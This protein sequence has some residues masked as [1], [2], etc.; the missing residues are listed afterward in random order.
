MEHE[1]RYLGSSTGQSPVLNLSKSNC[2]ASGSEGGGTGPEDEDEEDEGGES[3]Q[4]DVS[5]KEQDSDVAELSD[6]GE[7]APSPAT[8]SPHALNYS[9]ALTSGGPTQ[10]TSDPTISST[11][12]LLRNIQGLLKVAADNARQQE[13]QINYEKGLILRYG[14]L[15]GYLTETTATVDVDAFEPLIAGCCRAT[16]TNPLNIQVLE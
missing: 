10:P 5:D 14:G 13:R 7:G 9:A 15:S 12:T 1:T 4:D 11:E 16:K 3:D 6:T 8:A 2:E